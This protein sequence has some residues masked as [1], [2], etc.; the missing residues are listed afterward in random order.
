MKKQFYSLLGIS[1]LSATWS[2]GQ[3]QER[4]LDKSNMREG[5]HVEYCTTHKK[6]NELKSN[7]QFAKEYAKEQ[8]A[9]ENL[10]LA[11]KG[12]NGSTKAIVYTIPVV[13]HILH[14]GGNENISKDQILSA[15]DILNRDYAMLNADTISI[16]APFQSLKSKVDIQFVL[17]TKA[18]NGACFSG[19]T[20]TQNALTNDGSSGSAQINAIVAGNDVFN[21]Q[22]PGNKYLNIYVCKEIGGAAG[23][24]M[25]PSSF[26][27]TSMQNGIFILDT[28]T[29]SIGTSNVG[30]S[31]ALTHEVGHWLNLD[32]V[33]GG[34][35]NPGSAG[36]G[37]SDNVQDTPATQGSTVCNLTANTCSTD[38]AYWGF[39]QIDNVENYM[40]YSYCSKMFTIGQVNRMRTALTVSNTGRANVISG[41]N[42]TAVGASTPLTLCTA[43]F[44][45]PRTVICAGESITF[46]D[47][48]YNVAT[49]W[50][51]TF[52]GGSPASST[53]QNPTITYNTPGTYAVQLQATDGTN[54]NTANIPSYITVLPA[55]GNL[56]FYESFEASM[57]LT[58]PNWFVYNS[59]GAAAWAVT[60]TAAKTGTNSA[61]LDN[62][63][64]TTG[65]IDELISGP[66]DLSS[67]TSGTGVTLSFRYA[68]RKKISSNTDLLKVFLTKDCGEV[69]DVR[70][71]LTAATMSGTNTATSAWTPT[72]ADWVTVHM[73]N[74]TSV[75]WNDNFRCKFQVTN[76]GGNNVY[77]DDINIYSGGP[78]ENPVT[79]GLADLGTVANINLFPNPADNEVQISFSSQIANEIN[80][81][82]TDLSGKRIQQHQ[83]NATEGNNLVYIATENLSAGTYL[84]QMVDGT[85]QRTLTFVKK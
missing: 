5:E 42:L 22:W 24:T 55:G 47:E 78:S 12:E 74:V 31:R 3:Q 35:N 56:P 8:Q 15:L 52:T 38:N 66:I 37:G 36:C 51:W 64:Q 39:D 32:H 6:M 14:N 46:T 43:K 34:N 49:G 2:F 7:P 26:T 40:D 9:F 58:S 30:S 21:G 60:N 83:I 28:Y 59:G 68:Y 19:I 84:I 67:I 75:Y 25:L 70:K 29:G 65:Q 20:R 33:W 45:T 1:L 11:K 23:Y 82:V 80:F 53:T 81:Y 27:A 16:Q 85:S 71:T 10:M 79:A 50:T 69:W 72:A 4:V 17:A 73:T 44:S 54:N 63:S 41:A 57:N 62:F 76:G 61:K 13:F 18:P 77:I 48:S